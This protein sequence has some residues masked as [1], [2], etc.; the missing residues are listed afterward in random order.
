MG[1]HTGALRGVF[2]FL[3]CLTF[4]AQTPLGDAAS[5]AR[6]GRY[7]EARDKLAGVP[8]PQTIPQ[9]IAFHRLKAA[10]ASGL[11]ESATAASEMQAALSLA[12]SDPVL[13]V[14]TAVAEQGAGHLDRALALAE[15]AGE[16]ATAK[17]ILGDIQ[18]KQG[19]FDEAV[20]AYQQ[21]IALD[22]MREQYRV[23]LGLEW[24][25]HGAFDGATELLRQSCSLFPKS[26]VL[27]TLLAIAVYARGE[28]KESEQILNDAITVDPGYR[29]AYRCLSKIVLESSAVPSKKTLSALCQWD[30]TVCSAL[31]LRV[32]RESGD[33]KLRDQAVEVL[34]RAPQSD[35][36]SRCALGQAYEWS[37]QLAKAR[38][39]TE[40]C[41]A[42][43]PSPKNYYRLGLLYQRLGETALAQKQLEARREMLRKMSEETAVGLSALQLIPKSGK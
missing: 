25:E 24:I 14:G 31:Q 26:G 42:L 11:G 4:F 29:P 17:A 38:A 2:L 19:H 33:A 10:V 22:P 27:R 7:R 16:N 40:R 43:D 21:A 1:Y 20:N 30:Q 6:A 28:A 5:L 9:R 37:N 36:V 41:V 12:P 34:A 3:L 8:E 23:A 32:A 35:P 13:I 18:E 39:E 15:R